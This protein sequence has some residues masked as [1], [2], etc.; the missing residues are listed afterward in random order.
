MSASTN[1]QEAHTTFLVANE[2]AERA[3]HG[4][5]QPNDLIL[6][7]KCKTHGGHGRAGR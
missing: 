6:F 4:F 3:L 1:T 7:V 5:V 2:I